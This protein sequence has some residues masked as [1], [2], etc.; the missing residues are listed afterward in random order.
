MNEIFCPRQQIGLRSLAGS[1]RTINN[2]SLCHNF[3]RAKRLV[4]IMSTSPKLD[5]KAGDN[6]YSCFRI[7]TQEKSLLKSFSSVQNVFLLSQ[8]TKSH[9]KARELISWM[10][11]DTAIRTNRHTYATRSISNRLIAS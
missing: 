9:A 11:H 10:K 5:A 3:P 2:D 4:E 1:R 7:L 8:K 6:R